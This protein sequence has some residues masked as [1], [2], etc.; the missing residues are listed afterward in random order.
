MLIIIR[1]SIQYKITTRKNINIRNINQLTTS[2]MC[3]IEISVRND[4]NS[5]DRVCDRRIPVIGR[6]TPRRIMIHSGQGVIQ[7]VRRMGIGRALS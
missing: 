1:I 6:S 4:R 3:I 7:W 2:K 5:T